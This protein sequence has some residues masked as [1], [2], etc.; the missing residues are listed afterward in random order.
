M[1]ITQAQEMHRIGGSASKG[2]IRATGEKNPA[3]LP[4]FS[5]SAKAPTEL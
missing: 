2:R 3:D 1:L 5:C 4:G